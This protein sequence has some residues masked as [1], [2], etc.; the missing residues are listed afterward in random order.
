PI[1]DFDL[2]KRQQSSKTALSLKQIKAIEELDIEEDSSLWHT[3]NYFLFSFYN[4]GIRVGDLM[5]LKRGDV[6]VSDD[7]IRLRYLMNKTR[8]N[9][10]PKWKNIKQLPQAIE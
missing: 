9:T 5:K 6:Y 2:P 8:K 1:D 4:A 3:R 7:E 10:K